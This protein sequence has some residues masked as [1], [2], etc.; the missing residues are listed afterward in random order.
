MAEG[1]KEIEIG[2]NAAYLVE[3]I[4]HFSGAVQLEI[5]DAASPTR[6]TGDIATE[7]FYVLMPMRV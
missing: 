3:A 5:I 4:S 7:P 2:F 6:L 1:G